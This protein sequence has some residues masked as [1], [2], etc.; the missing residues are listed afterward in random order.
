MTMKFEDV[1]KVWERAGDPTGFSIT[2]LS[3]LTGIEVGEV[4]KIVA[5]LQ[6][7]GF[8]EEKQRGTFTGWIVKRT[9]DDIAEIDL[10]DE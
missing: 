10:D 5:K 2:K 1:V 7:E 9:T 3:H 8:I 4:K 6:E